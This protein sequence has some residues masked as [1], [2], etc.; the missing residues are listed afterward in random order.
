MQHYLVDKFYLLEVIVDNGFKGTQFV[1]HHE[2]IKDVGLNTKDIKKYISTNK[3]YSGFL[4]K[5]IKRYEIHDYF[6]G[7]PEG[8]KELLA[9]NKKY[10]QCNISPIIG[11]VLVGKY[12]GLKFSLFGKEEIN[13]FFNT[14][15][16]KRN[17]I[18][19]SCYF[20]VTSHKKAIPLHGLLNE[21]VKKDITEYS[22]FRINT[23]AVI[24]TVL[25]GRY[26]GLSFGLIGNK[27]IDKYFNNGNVHSVVNGRIKQA[28]NC[29][30]KR[31]TP[32]E[33]IL[34]KDI[35]TDEIAEEIK[36]YI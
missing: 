21:D 7:V 10:F 25:T 1:L 24:G 31:V 26:K 30:F 2:N 28:Y 29:S 33:A 8:I 14:K 36:L 18:C 32:Q 27:E 23:F 19:K 35:L 13:D 3:N 16:I 22:N 34:L 15:T 17:R 20:E 5:K 12:K 11:T 9:K 4:I 6:N